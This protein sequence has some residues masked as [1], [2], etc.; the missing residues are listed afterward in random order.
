[1]TNPC[2]IGSV[3]RA[4]GVGAGILLAAMLA[5]LCAA[6]VARAATTPEFYATTIAEG[7]ASGPTWVEAI[8]VSGDGKLDLVTALSGSDSVSVRL[9][10]GAGGFGAASTYACGGDNPYAVAVA[11]LNGDLLPD[12]AVTNR[13]SA[14]VTVLQGLGGGVFNLANTISVGT[15]A[16]DVKAL[17]LDKDGDL[18]LAATQMWNDPYTAGKLWLLYNNGSAVF[19][20]VD[21]PLPYTGSTVM[22]VG[23]LNKDGAMDVAVGHGYPADLPDPASPGSTE[24]ILLNDNLGSHVDGTG[25]PTTNLVLQPALTVGPYPQGAT[26]ADF[27]G[28][29]NKDICITSRYPNYANIFL[30]DG[31]GALTGPTTYG[32]GPYAKVPVAVD[33]NKDGAQDIAV[34]NYGNSNDSNTTISILTGVGNGTFNSQILVTVGDKP[35]SVAVG[36]LNGDTWPDLVVPNWASNDVTVLLNMT[37]YASDGTDP[38]TTISPDDAW[39]PGPVTVTLTATDAGSGVAETWY[40]IDGG[41]WTLGKSFSVTAEGDTTVGYYSVDRM[42]NEET[43]HT[44]HIKI[45]NVAPTTTTSTDSAWH[46]GAVS[47][48]LTPTDSRSGVKETK[49]RVDGGTWQTGKSFSISTDRDHALD[50]YSVDVAGNQETTHNT[51][52]KIDA[53]L[54]VVNVTK[55]AADAAYGQNGGNV[56]SWTSSDA[57]SGVAGEAAKIDGVAVA[58]GATIDTGAAGKHTFVLTVTDAAGNVSTVTREYTVTITAPT[59]LKAASLQ[60]TVTWGGSAVLSAMLTDGASGASLSGQPVQLEWSSDQADWKLLSTVTSDA[61]ACTA[62]AQPDKLTYYR[63]RFLGDSVHAP[64]VSETIVVKVKP[65]VSKPKA[66]SKVKAGARFSVTGTLKPLFASGSKTVKIKTYRYRSGKW[67]F[68]K[69][70]SA[71]NANSGS[72]SKYSVKIRLAKGKYRFSASTAATAAWAAATTGYSRSLVVK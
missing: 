5:V 6:G 7:A 60:A 3:R 46:K 22:G 27:N 14:T 48:T 51:R 25:W 37:N 45:D 13:S 8:D 23:D 12:I 17:D 41:S 29:G 55:P 19:K 61:G 59:T 40:Q 10:D 47:V 49:Y 43:H 63:F 50:Y 70:Y 4:S 28:D 36:D 69:T 58:K 30:G 38:V 32:V 65:A 18:D 54:P 26:F 33:L 9:G 24:S 34:C 53:T 44:A 31:T 1:M 2:G 71:V 35:H 68:F 56:C 16:I 66:P 57:T 11:N 39:R 64:A 15:E 72:Y 42:G 21:M 62:S 67:V 20:T 52:V